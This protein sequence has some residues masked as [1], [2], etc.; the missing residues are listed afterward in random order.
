MDTIYFDRNGNVIFQ[1]LVQK[2][3]EKKPGYYNDRSPNTLCGDLSSES[4]WFCLLSWDNSDVFPGGF[5]SC[6]GITLLSF[7]VVLPPVLGLGITLMSFLVVLPPVLG[8][9]ITLMS[10]LVVLPSC[11]GIT[12]MSFLVVFASCLGITLMSFLVVLPPVLG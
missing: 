10:F 8:L 12:L 6:L 1:H 7:L 9:G 4:W 2:K 3:R 11:L 5:A